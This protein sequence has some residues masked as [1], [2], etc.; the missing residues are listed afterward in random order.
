M[1]EG[2]D[3][4]VLAEAIRELPPSP[5]KDRLERLWASFRRGGRNPGALNKITNYVARN[6][7]VVFMVLGLAAFGIYTLAQVLSF[8]HSKPK[9]EER[10]VL[11]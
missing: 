2:D 6:P 3:V 4:E 10:G 9:E 1:G 7:D 11:V 5:E 8:F